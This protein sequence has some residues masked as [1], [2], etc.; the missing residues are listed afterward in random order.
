MF[1]SDKIKEIIGY[2]PK[3]T[4]YVCFADKHYNLKC[5][6]INSD[7]EASNYYANHPYN[8]NSFSFTTRIHNV[9]PFALHPFILRKRMS[10]LISVA[11]VD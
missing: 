1:Y 5:K 11:I 2:F 4:L 8:T 6:R 9:I 7:E 10:D 3:D